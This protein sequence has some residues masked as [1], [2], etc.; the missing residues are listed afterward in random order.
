MTQQQKIKQTVKRRPGEG[1]EKEGGRTTNT[2]EM[3]LHGEELRSNEG[4]RVSKKREGINEERK[5][6]E[7]GG[8]VRI[9]G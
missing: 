3:G 7:E 5:E 9:W 6:N 8:V 4:T 2:G 1:V